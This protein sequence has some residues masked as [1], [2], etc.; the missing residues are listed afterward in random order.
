MCSHGV[1]LVMKLNRLQAARQTVCSAEVERVAV[2]QP[3]IDES[4]GHSR[5]EIPEI[6]ILS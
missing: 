5:P 6:S 3:S 2:I 4:N 1:T